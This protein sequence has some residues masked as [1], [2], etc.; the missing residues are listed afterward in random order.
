MK[1]VAGSDEIAEMNGVI[2]IEREKIRSHLD[3]VV[4][5]SVQETICNANRCERSADRVDLRAESCERKLH[6]KAGEVTQEAPRLWTRAPETQI[7]ERRR[8]R[9][10]RGRGIGRDA[11]GGRKRPPRRGLYGGAVGGRVSPSTVRE[12][13]QKD[14]RQ[15]KARRNRPI[16]GSHPYVFLD[17][18]WLK[19]SWRVRD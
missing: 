1:S 10:Q 14:R 13:K 5:S 4:R 7:I 8:R 18:V 3:E 16:E 15:G 12:L 6:V 11:S 2:R 19:R 9:E 17:G